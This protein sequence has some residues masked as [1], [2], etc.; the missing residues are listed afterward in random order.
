[1]ICLRQ[2]TP[3]VLRRKPLAF[4]QIQAEDHFDDTI[5][6]NEK[7]APPFG[8]Q[9]QHPFNER[10][11]LIPRLKI[12]VAEDSELQ[13]LYLCSL[14]SGLGYEAIEAEDGE[15][16]LDLV[17]STDASIVISDL[18]M[19]NLNGIGLTQKIRKLDLGYYVHVFMV[20]GADETETRVEALRAGADDFIT[21]G[22]S[23][24]MLKA[25]IRTATRLI[26][27][28]AELAERTRILKEANERIQEDLR[29]AAAA[30]RQLLP[31]LQDDMM[32]FGIASVFVPSAIVSGDM[33]GCFAL[34]DTQFGFY[35][36]DVSGHGVHA[37]LL[38]V[39]IGHLIAP[40][41]VRTHAF[42]PAGRPDPAAMVATLNKRFSASEND[43]YFTMFCGVIDT[44][45]GHMD[46]CQ[47]GYPSAFY[48]DQAGV[49]SP[50]G[51]G[52][53]PVGMISTASYENKSHHFE[54]GAA[55]IIC[56]DAAAEAGNLLGE[57]FGDTRVREIA[58]SFPKIGIDK[59][60]TELVHAL[61]TW[62]DGAP[63]EDDLTVVALE[64]KP[65]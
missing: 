34:N 18:N 47:A 7:L 12:I 40:D 64:R 39:S 28:A 42:D 5:I 55:L 2:N 56:S 11:M 17:T 25:R 33:F 45:T 31:N 41:Y 13:R 44:A 36:V 10:H 8:P 53:F 65:Q 35:A 24:E 30:Q 61:N 3:Q 57:P 38:S 26:N 37:S 19:P 52:G 6:I 60:P 23:T 27:H 32:G 54:T 51:D 15:V 50:V 20:T 9:P 43:D 46:Y 29:A 21:K 58:Q 59:I 22:S 63:L 14:I 62:R 1:L 49:T 48:V 4:A 16:A